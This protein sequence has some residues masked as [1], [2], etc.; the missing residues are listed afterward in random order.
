MFDRTDLDGNIFDPEEWDE[1]CTRFA[2]PGGNSCLHPESEN[3]PRNISCPTCEA[4]NRLTP[5]DVTKGYHCDSCANEQEFG[6]GY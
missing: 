5:L 1:M 4:P 6:F 2:D 3:N